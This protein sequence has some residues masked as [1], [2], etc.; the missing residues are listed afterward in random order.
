MKTDVFPLNYFKNIW[1][2]KQI[3]QQKHSFN[4]FQLIVVLLFLNGLM[5][6]PVSLNYA[7]METFSV[8]NTFPET[9]QMIDQTVVDTMKEAAFTSG[10]M[11]LEEP[12]R[13]QT[14]N[15]VVAGSLTEQEAAQILQ[16]DG[17]VLL[18]LENELQLREKGQSVSIVPYT[19]D[20][21][22]TAATTVRE[23]QDAISQQWFIKNQTFVIAAFS[24]ILFALLLTEL[25][26]LIFVAAFFLYIASKNKQTGN[27]KLYKES[28]ATVLYAA[29]VP[30]IAAMA[31]GL[32]EFNVITM[33][34]IQ[35]VGLIGYIWFI[36]YHNRINELKAQKAVKSQKTQIHY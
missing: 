31:V 11:N 7:K 18:F 32:F 6:I 29:G 19:K 15:G 36:Y 35:S 1:T 2:P 28:V 25:S 27:R 20:F 10:E 14:D 33:V 22:L 34:T 8:Q 24:S 23:F 26:L 16:E 17:S 30:S 21:D 9:F 12:F 4:W 5:I 3:V 13:I